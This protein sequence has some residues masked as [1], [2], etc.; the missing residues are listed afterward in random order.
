MF[1]AQTAALFF[2]PLLCTQALAAPCCKTQATAEEL[3]RAIH[4]Y[5]DVWNGNFSQVDSVFAPSLTVQADLIPQPGGGTGAIGPLITTSAAFASWVQQ[6][7]ANFDTYTF[8]LNK[9]AAGNNN[10]AGRWTLNAE[11]GQNFTFLPTNLKR[12][13]PVTYNGTDFLTLDPCTGLVVEVAVAQDL[14]SLIV[15]LGNVITI[16]PKATN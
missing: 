15:N 7:R 14:I 2:A 11:I 10:V 16:T 6:A 9:Y 5:L 1:R 3:D 8:T 13:D 4:G 12:G